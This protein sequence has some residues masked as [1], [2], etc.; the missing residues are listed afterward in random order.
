MPNANVCG[1]FAQTLFLGASITSFSSSIGWNGDQGTLEVEVVEDS[2]QGTKVFYDTYGNP[3]I[4][5]QAD[6]FNPPTVGSAIFFKF[7]DYSFGGIL[8]SWEQTHDTQAGKTYS[9]RCTDAVEVLEG[10]QAIINNYTGS[11]FGVPNLINVFG[12]QEAQNS[13]CNTLSSIGSLNPSLGY[14]PALGFGGAKVNEDGMSWNDIRQALSVLTSSPSTYGGQVQLR[15]TRY[16]VDISELPLLDANFRINGDSV[17]LLELVSQVCAAAGM[18]YFIETL[19]YA[20]D[21]VPPGYG[22]ISGHLHP[23]VW[24]FIKIRT[25]SRFVQKTAAYNVDLTVGSPIDSRLSLGAISSFVG[26]GVGNNRIARGLELRNDITNSF[27]IGDNRQDL[28]QQ[29]YS[30]SANTYTDTIWPYWGV[31]NLG[32]PIISNGIDNEHQFTISTEGWHSDLVAALGASYTINMLEIRAA[33]AG[34]EEWSLY[35]IT[36]KLAQAVALHMDAAFIIDDAQVIWDNNKA[37]HPND[38]K[39]TKK[40]AIKDAK[41]AGGARIEGLEKDFDELQR[42]LFDVVKSYGDLA[43]KKFMVSL[44]LI[45]SAPSDELPFAVKLNWQKSDGAWTDA[46]VQLHA[47]ADPLVPT[48]PILEQFRLE[49]GRIQCFVYFN[50]TDEIFR[51]DYTKLSPDDVIPISETEC[52]VKATLEHITFLN[53]IARTYP[54]A[55]VSIASQI[56]LARDKDH[57]DAPIVDN[58]LAL[59]ADIEIP[60]GWIVD[61]KNAAF[62]DDTNKL[63]IYPFILMP[64]GA[65]IPLVSTNLCYG[66]WRTTLSF[67]P[68]AKTSY[69]RDPSI[70]PWSFGGTNTM[71][72]AGQVKVE[73]QVTQQ[74]VN[75]SGSLTVPGAPT[76]RLGSLLVAGGPEITNIDVQVG[77]GGVT[78]SMRFRTWVKNFGEIGRRRVQN[79]RSAGTYQQKLQRAFIKNNFAPNK[80]VAFGNWIRELTKSDRFNRNSSHTVLAAELLDDWE[81]EEEETDYRRPNVVMTDLRKVLPET[82]NNYEKKAVMD[83]SGMFRAFETSEVEGHDLPFFKEVTPEDGQITDQSLNPF[84]TSEVHNGESLGHDIEIL[85]RG[86][87][88]DDIEDLSIRKDDYGSG[89]F[90]GVGLRAPLVLVG[91]GFD[92]NGKPVPNENEETPTDNFATDYLR[93]PQTWKAGPLDVRWDEDRGVWSA[94]GGTALIKARLDSTLTFR[95]SA[96]AHI[97]KWNAEDQ[98]DQEEGNT[99]TVYDWL[100]PSGS[101]VSANTN[102][103]ISAEQ[104][105]DPNRY[106]VINAS[107][108]TSNI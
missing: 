107:C 78:T 4:T 43:G 57:P 14:T 54:R 88:L 59:L 92:L 68:A 53:P 101:F 69:E 29:S 16:F 76:G 83:L 100:L 97:Y 28:W 6:F 60:P 90:R 77:I 84:K 36:K 19:Y 85:T 89:P 48:S 91:W 51:I 81:N 35:M 1:P 30:G 42:F 62:G 33:L 11:T 17:T 87:S 38:L 105:G 31:D 104:G 40:D 96:S 106:Y 82:Y 5:N 2:C 73:T 55:V 64:I 66:P 67:G 108:A 13:S 18:D 9:I 37:N 3:Q 49:D 44:P 50:T 32:F 8:Q 21:Y 46:N 58:L 25:S 45:C 98:E 71:N 10:C 12:Y 80:K 63:P 23:D 79:L 75:E 86:N 7:G 41:R 70:N 34:L 20:P 93:K 24:K 102:V 103:F 47:L 99:I 56:T 72:Y 74:I 94:A 65:A 39:R 27:L 15:S 26:N 22:G 95:S 52:Y 61:H